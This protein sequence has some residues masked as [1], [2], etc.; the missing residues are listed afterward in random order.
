MNRLASP[1]AL[2]A[3]LAL[4][5]LL[6]LWW[7]ASRRPPAILYSDLELPGPLPSTWRIRLRHLPRILRVAF[8]I[9]A[10][11]ALARPQYGVR[12][13]EVTTHGVDIVIVLDRSGSMRALDLT[14]DRL[15]VAKRTIKNFVDGRP[16]DRLGLVPFAGEAYTACPLTLDHTALLELLDAVDFATRDEDGTAIGLGLAAAVGRLDASDAKSRVIILVTDGVNNTGAIAPLTAAELARDKGMRVYTIGIGTHG[17]ARLP[18]QGPSGRWRV[19]PV[20]VE[21]DEGTLR[22]IAKMTGGQYFR[23]DE[24]G[25][26][27]EIFSTIDGLERSEIKS[28]L[29]V[30]WTDRFE[31]WLI[32][33]GLLLLAEIFVLRFF[34]GRLP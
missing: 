14:P 9:L 13:E 10:A 1:W 26:I 5:P 7:R 24:N 2:A 6:A 17:S 20:P 8:F 30:A 32:A 29:H 16:H 15:T 4:L 18:V 34:F 11:I 25:K 12:S 3:L 33:A 31:G 23:A 21:I 22:Q 28:R 27:E 19:I